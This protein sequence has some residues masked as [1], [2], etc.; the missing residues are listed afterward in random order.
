MG[1]TLLLLMSSISICSPDPRFFLSPHS[2]SGLG[3]LDGMQQQSPMLRRG[4]RKCSGLYVVGS[5][6][7]IVGICHRNLFLKKKEDRRVYSQTYCLQE[8]ELYHLPSH[9]L[10][11]LPHPLAAE[12]QK[13]TNPDTGTICFLVEQDR[14]SNPLCIIHIWHQKYDERIRQSDERNRNNR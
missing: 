13:G 5:A 8:E 3:V 9:N 2:S 11:H 6:V 1:S 14:L 4:F 10:I 7:R 12:V